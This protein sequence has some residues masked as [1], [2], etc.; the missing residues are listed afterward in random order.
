MKKRNLLPL[1]LAAL[2]CLSACTPIYETQ[3]RCTVI[4]LNGEKTAVLSRI[5]E[6]RAAGYPY[7]V[8]EEY[9]G[10]PV[11]LALP[12]SIFGLS[13]QID[14]G[15]IQCIESRAFFSGEFTCVTLPEVRYIGYQAFYDSGVDRIYLS[16]TIEE[17]E[18]GAFF[19][20]RPVEIHFESAPAYLGEHF[21]MFTE[22][23][24]GYTVTVFGPADSFL[25]EYCER[26]GYVFTAE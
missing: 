13:D 3:A 21:V 6:H 16:K 25:P 14:L 26:N 17:I 2:L 22:D 9:D 1:F 5:Y 18:S 15:K 19:L 24:P 11:L 7:R 10:L 20:R 4:E 23:L 8:P 12:F